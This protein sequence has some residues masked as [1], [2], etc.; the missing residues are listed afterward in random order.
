MGWTDDKPS[1]MS[2]LLEHYRGAK[3]EDEVNVPSCSQKNIK[4]METEVYD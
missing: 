3:E 4:P 1:V 2:S